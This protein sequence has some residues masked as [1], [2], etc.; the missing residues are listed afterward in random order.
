MSIFNNN[1]YDFYVS[2]I[3]LASFH[4]FFYQKLICIVKWI[5]WNVK[6]DVGNSKTCWTIQQ[7]WGGDVFSFETGFNGIGKENINLKIFDVIIKTH[8]MYK[9]ISKFPIRFNNLFSGQT[10][11]RSFTLQIIYQYIFWLLFYLTFL[12]WYFHIF[13][14]L[15]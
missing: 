7:I 12:F 10:L 2:Y 14:C 6:C 1:F 5:L 11:T 8:S 13:D 15:V 3:T 4:V 9:R